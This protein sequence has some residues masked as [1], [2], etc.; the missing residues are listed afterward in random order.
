M[1][2]RHERIPQ[3]FVRMF[4]QRACVRACVRVCVNAVSIIYFLFKCFISCNS[5]VKKVQEKCQ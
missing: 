5:N 2:Y 1:F 3:G 4:G